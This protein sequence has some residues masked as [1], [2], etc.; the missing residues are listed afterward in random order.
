MRDVNTIPA[1]E[2]GKGSSIR[3]EI[4]ESDEDL[5][6]DIVRTM[7][8]TLRQNETL[9]KPTVM[10]VPVGPVG[11][12]SRLARICNIERMSLHN[13]WLFNMDEYLTEE[14]QWLPI[15]HPLSFRGHMQRSLLDLLDDELAPPAEQVVFP[16][17]HD[18]Q[19]VPKMMARLGGVDV[20][21]GGIGIN[22]HIAFNEPPE[23]GEQMSDEE[24]ADLPTRVVRLARET[25]TINSVTVAG[26]NIPLIPQ[27]AV[28]VGMR[29]CLSARE[30]RLYANRPWQRSVIRRVLHGPVTAEVPCSLVQTHSN[31]S[32]TVTQDVAVPP[33]KRL[34]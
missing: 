32:L 12:Y 20:C 26:G 1:D 15:D 24:F 2:L 14:G 7:L 27:S 5:Y 18:L 31:A 9:G 30:I 23:P 10:I 29:E 25:R 8:N 11:Q 33:E 13:L 21:Y 22:G 4:L 17:P 34:T 6:H 16:D 19:S 28:T 3:V